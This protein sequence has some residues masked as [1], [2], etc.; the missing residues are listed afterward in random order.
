MAKLNK[1]IDG[2][3]LIIS[4][5]Q[6][7]RENSKRG[8]SISIVVSVCND[9]D[10]KKNDRNSIMVLSYKIENKLKSKDFIKESLALATRQKKLCSKSN[11]MISCKANLPT[12]ETSIIKAPHRKISPPPP[13]RA[14]PHINTAG[15]K[16]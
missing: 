3:G 16:N 5:C 15:Q 10:K 14:L 4:N 1:Q 9:D 13:Y 11:S 2:T 7:G 12:I 6:K 8:C